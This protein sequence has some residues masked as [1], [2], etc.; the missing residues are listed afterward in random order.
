LTSDAD[1]TPVMIQTL[2]LCDIAEIFNA[3]RGASNFTAK[4]DVF[5]YGI[6]IYEV[7]SGAQQQQQSAAPTTAAHRRNKEISSI[8]W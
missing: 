8:P 5:S 1:I 6:V 7:L 4:S 3:R 2:F